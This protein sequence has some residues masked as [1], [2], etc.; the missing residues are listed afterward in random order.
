MFLRKTL[1]LPECETS[2]LMVSK[3]AFCLVIATNINN[4]FVGQKEKRTN[5]ARVSVRPEYFA[6]IQSELVI[7]LSASRVR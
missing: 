6:V 1:E 7:Y 3:L 5:K 4:Q 2:L